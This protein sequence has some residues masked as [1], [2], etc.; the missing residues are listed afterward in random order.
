MTKIIVK[1]FKKF[2]G[3]TVVFS[4]VFISGIVF[5]ATMYETTEFPIYRETEETIGASLG[6]EQPLFVETLNDGTVIKIATWGCEDSD[7]KQDFEPTAENMVLHFAGKGIGT[8]DCPDEKGGQM[9]K[10]TDS[11]KKISLFIIGP[12][13]VENEI[14]QKDYDRGLANKAKMTSVEKQSY[15]TQRLQDIQEAIQK[16]RLLENK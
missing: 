15:R 7:Y 14:I 16:A 9:F 2:G 8:Y 12:S 6:G 11:A 10:I 3:W 1:F 5:N 13:Y 4:I